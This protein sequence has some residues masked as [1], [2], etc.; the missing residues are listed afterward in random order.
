VKSLEILQGLEIGQITGILQRV[1]GG[2][3]EKLKALLRDE[4]EVE[5]KERILKFFDKNGRR[6]PPKGLQNNVCDPDKDFRLIQPGFKIIDNYAQRLIRFKQM[7][8]GPMSVAEFEGKTRELVSEIKSNELLVNLLNGTYLPI[9]LPQIESK[10]FDYGTT[11]E[12]M[13]LSA[14]KKAYEAQFPG[15]QFY[16]WRKGEL[17][18]QVS[19]VPGTR[20][21]ILVERIK[22]GN[23][24]AI[25][26]PNPLQG[27]SVLASREQM[28]RL[29]ESL[30]LVG[31][32]DASTAMVMYPDI[33]A[34]DWHTPGYDLS[35]FH[36]Q[37]SGDSLYFGADDGGLHLSSGASLGSAS[38]YYSSGLLFLGSAS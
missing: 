24:Y 22:Q 37:S 2:D 3:Q 17:A 34:R 26:F 14:V 6:I 21:E 19:I 38:G 16:N 7:F 5:L 20:H 9:I 1:S 11:L 10:N 30:I 8:P 33:L 35:A 36:W 12:N 23:V 13:F 27:F 29:S 31:G 25:Y 18:K 28:S 15:R 4:L 32:F